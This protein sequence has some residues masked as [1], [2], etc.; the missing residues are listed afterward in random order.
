MSIITAEEY[1]LRFPSGD[2]TNRAGYGPNRPFVPPFKTPQ[3]IGQLLLKYEYLKNEPY[4][5]YTYGWFGL[6][7]MAKTLWD[8]R[9]EEDWTLFQY[10]NP[11][12]AG[13]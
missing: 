5:T 7:H 10:D 11:W 9:P 12:A 6:F 4:A 1:E 8:D 3:T 13:G 2:H